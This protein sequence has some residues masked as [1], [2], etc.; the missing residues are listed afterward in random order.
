MVDKQTQTF[1]RINLHYEP[2]IENALDIFML[3]NKNNDGY[4]D[5][6]E[7]EPLRKV[8]MNLIDEKDRDAIKNDEDFY[9][10]FKSYNRYN[11][12]A[13]TFKEILDEVRIDYK[14][15]NESLYD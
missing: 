7:T 15:V 9:K 11:V 4:I 5:F 8:M 12:D 3:L 6:D 1:D 10:V 13:L 14:K 2:N